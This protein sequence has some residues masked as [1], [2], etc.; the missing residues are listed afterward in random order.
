MHKKNASDVLMKLMKI[1][2]DMPKNELIQLFPL[3]NFDRNELLIK[4]LCSLS[5][6][7][8][9]KELIFKLVS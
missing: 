6:L 8:N 1:S 3:I 2:K 7:S 4:D 9:S 5:Q